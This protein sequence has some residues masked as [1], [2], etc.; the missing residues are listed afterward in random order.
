MALGEKLFE[1]IG[2]ITG[3][4]KIRVNPFEGVTTEIRIAKKGMII[5]ET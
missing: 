2:N 1:E 3:L 4:K 5:G